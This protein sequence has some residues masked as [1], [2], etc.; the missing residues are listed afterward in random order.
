MNYKIVE[1]SVFAR[2]ARMVLKSDNVAMVLGKTI[3]LSGVKKDIFLN[4]KS[5]F[6]HGCCH[7]RQFQK[8]GFFKFLWLYLIESIK[9]GY[10]HNK[11]EEEARQ[12]EKEMQ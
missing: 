3:H 11:F 2:V 7:I 10:Y 6:A 5:W 9:V 12:A 1:N 8:Y 4:N